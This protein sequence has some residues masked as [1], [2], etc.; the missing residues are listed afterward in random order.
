[1]SENYPQA[2]SIIDTIL[3]K[4]N[5]KEEKFD[6]LGRKHYFLELLDR[7]HPV[8][9]DLLYEIHMTDR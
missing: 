2:I 6:L 8:L 1:M 7:D 4:S 3:A 9:T 5:D